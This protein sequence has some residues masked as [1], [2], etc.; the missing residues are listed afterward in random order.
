MGNNCDFGWFLVVLASILCFCFYRLEDRRPIGLFLLALAEGP[1]GSLVKMV[2]DG[3]SQEGPSGICVL[4][5]LFV[6]YITDLLIV[7]LTLSKNSA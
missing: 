2:T 7:Y 3:V 5:D 1:S 4:S 6:F